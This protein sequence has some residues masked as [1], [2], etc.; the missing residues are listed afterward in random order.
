M[1]ITTLAKELHISTETIK[2]FIQDFDL[3]L[4]H[5]LDTNLSVKPDF[6]KFLRENIDF[7]QKYETDLILEK[8]SNDIAYEIDEPI[9]KVEEVIKEKLPNLFENG[10]YKSSVSS[11]GIHHQ[12]GGD[13]QFVYNY[14]GKKTQLA[15]RNFIGYRD[16]YFHIANMLNPIID[17]QQ[18]KDWGIS[19][20]AGIMLYGPKGSGKI[21][22]AR[23][24]SEMINYQ[25]QEVKKFYLSS[26]FIN[27]ERNDFKDFLFSLMNKKEPQ[28]LFLENFHNIAKVRTIEESARSK[29]EK[30]KNTILNTMHQFVDENLLMIASAEELSGIDSEVLSPGRFDIKIPVF[31][32]NS[33]ER[34]QMMLRYLTL[35]LEKD[36]TLMQI[37]EFNKADH[38]PFWQPIANRMKLFSNTMVIDFTQS[39]KKRLRNHYLKVKTPQFDIS[40]KIIELCYIECASKLNDEYL[41]SIQEFIRQVSANDYDVFARRIEQ[42]KKELAFYTIKEKPAR[43]IGFDTDGEE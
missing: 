7:L 23:K 19:K 11:Y 30:I 16:L 4:C 29:Y 8:S 36:A 1:K 18:A 34:A 21:F 40:S 41:V 10:M 2:Q 27:D 42:M 17:E 26:S 13:Y 24:I 25:F 38:K 9:E 31:P 12:L 39:L 15:Q 33:D 22:W 5:T 35:D 37:L 3:D 20:P 6:E 14:F 32:P 28:I 43:K